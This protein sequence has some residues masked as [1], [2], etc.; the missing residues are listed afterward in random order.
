MTEAAGSSVADADA[1][2]RLRPWWSRPERWL[3][4]LACL[5]AGFAF[6]SV[7]ALAAGR[8]GPLPVGLGTIL[9]GGGL[10]VV[11]VDRGPVPRRAADPIWFWL[12]AAAIAATA[13]AVNAAHA[14]EHLRLDRDPAAYLHAA[15]VLGD[16][17]SPRVD[18]AEGGFA[19][20]ADL[21]QGGP[22][23]FALDDGSYGFQGL[24]LLPAA[25]AAASWIGG[26]A[27]L[28]RVP[29]LLGGAMLLAFLALARRVVGPAPALVAGVALACLLPFAYASRDHL[30]EILLTPALLAALWLLLAIVRPDVGDVTPPTPSAA[31]LRALAPGALLGTVMMTR[32]DAGL[33]VAGVVGFVGLWA[34]GVRS[35]PAPTPPSEQARRRAVLGGLAAGIGPGIALALLAGRR[36]AMPY[37]EAHASELRAVGALLAATAIGVAAWWAVDPRLDRA[38]ARWRRHRSRVGTVGAVAIVVAFGLLVWVRPHVQEARSLGASALVES[39][40][41]RDGLDV[42]PSRSY[43]ESSAVWLAWYL[44][45]FGL[46]T[47][48]VGLAACTRRVV[49]GRPGPE[50]LVLAT[51]V[52]P[53]VLYLYRPSIYPD[54]LWAT[55]RYLPVV[56]PLLILLA[57]WTIA[58]VA[59][60]P[61][62]A[63]VRAARWPP[64]RWL[65]TRWRPARAAAVAALVVA[66]VGGPLAATAPVWRFQVYD[67]MAAQVGE[68]CR[69]LPDDAVLLGVGDTQ[70]TTTRAFATVCDRPAATVMTAD[71]VPPPDMVARVRAG[72]EAEGRTLWLVGTDPALLER[73]GSGP[74]TVSVRT[75]SNVLRPT[76]THRPDT[77]V[78]QERVLAVAPA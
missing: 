53:L 14:N 40:Q 71:G 65:T 24:H 74:P 3:A 2:A 66:V 72:W 56:F 22:G 63:R 55:R 4:V 73:V 23:M 33:A 7:A 76:L 75:E 62:P 52:P 41:R 47:A 37:L 18:R 38:P 29:A 78:E 32:I 17:G 36:N 45:P 48:V 60:Q 54:H 16:H 28:L 27:A 1:G 30:S 9:L 49:A 21:A 19:G 64:A 69:V 39:I 10:A 77:L 42:D 59:R 70:R 6:S 13:T 51:L 68:L 57:A 26:E 35:G 50:A 44:G 31:G 43:D 34:G 20:E 58:S 5:G 67:D 8:F 15:Y 11:G 61:V 12:A 25:A 46:A